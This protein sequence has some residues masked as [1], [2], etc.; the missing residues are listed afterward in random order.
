[1][2]DIDKIRDEMAEKH[3]H[4]GVVMIGEYVSER[5]MKGAKLPEGKTL[6]GAFEEIRK[7]A[8][9]HKTGN[10][11]F[12]PPEKAYEIVDAYFGFDKD[13]EAQVV[14]APVTQPAADALDLDALLGEW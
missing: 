14:P 5:L 12:V 13:A 6:L 8:S 2:M 10:Y 7:Y 3:D 11:C 9:K 4:S 1:M